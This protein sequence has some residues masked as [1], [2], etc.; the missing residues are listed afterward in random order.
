MKRT[1][2]LW[3]ELFDDDDDNV[4][5]NELFNDVE[6]VIEKFPVKS[7]FEYGAAFGLLSIQVSMMHA[8]RLGNLFEFGQLFK[9]FGN[10]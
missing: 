1:T 6:D 4:I 10:N 8:T 3:P 2:I 7:D 5:S 9:A